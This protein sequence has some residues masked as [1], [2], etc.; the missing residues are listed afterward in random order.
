MPA[1]TARYTLWGYHSGAKGTRMRRVWAALV[2]LAAVFVLHGVQCAGHDLSSWTSGAAA[3]TSPEP[4]T[5]AT[6]HSSSPAG[7]S[8]SP[9]EPH[10]IGAGS[11]DPQQPHP[12][13]GGLEAICLAVL[14]AGLA[15]LVALLLRPGAPPGRSRCHARAQRWVSG[16]ALLR[17]PDLFVLCVMRN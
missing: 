17:P 12:S 5:S 15:L 10:R 3:Q 7:G 6:H 11:A 14:S 9:V 16:P 13:S 8:A 1:P 2:A 4:A